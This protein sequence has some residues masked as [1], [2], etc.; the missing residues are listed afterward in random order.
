M[1][2]LS[3]LSISK[4]SPAF[5]NFNAFS[6]LFNFH[7]AAVVWA[8]QQCPAIGRGPGE[9]KLRTGRKQVLGRET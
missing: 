9:G 5:Y 8:S 2:S 1:V 4:Y 3:T 7:L 6:L